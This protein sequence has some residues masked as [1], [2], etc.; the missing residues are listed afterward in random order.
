MTEVTGVLMPHLMHRFSLRV[1]V[2]DQDVVDTFARQV[3]C[4]KFDYFNNTL[5]MIIEQPMCG[6]ALHQ[7]V[8]EWI[9][10]N[11][12]SPTALEIWAG[13]EED[14]GY[15][16]RFINLRCTSHNFELGYERSETAKHKL[17]FNFDHL[18]MGDLPE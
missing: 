11:K 15:I 16:L 4:V 7:F 1:R 6:G 2:K 8:Y 12:L 3:L 18:V 14:P 9:H 13:P 5:D 10:P 17:T